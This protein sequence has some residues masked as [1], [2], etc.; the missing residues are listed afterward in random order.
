AL[1][2]FLAGKKPSPDRTVAKGSALS[3]GQ[4]TASSKQAVS[5][6]TDVAPVLQKSCVSCH[7]PGNIGP[8]AMASYEKVKGRS[9]MI[10]EVL[11]SQRMP[12]WHADP[13]YG[14]F[15]N[16]RALSPEQ[17][18]TLVQWV[19]QGCPRGEGEDPLETKPQ[20]AADHWPLGKPDYVVKF[21]KTEEIADNGVFNY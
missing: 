13:H 21:P 17:A 4:A 8:F 20:P 9:S 2:S 5:Y 1:T 19:E 7:S 15:S 3:F 12:P 16:E 14:S 10:R 6:V 11:L 18:H